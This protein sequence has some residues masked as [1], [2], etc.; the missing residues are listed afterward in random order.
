MTDIEICLAAE[1]R[2]WSALLENDNGTPDFFDD[3]VRRTAPTVPGS[4]HFWP[5]W[6]A[7]SA[8]TPSSWI[9]LEHNYFGLPPELLEEWRTYRKRW[10]DL[11]ELNPRM[12]IAEMLSDISEGHDSSSFPHGWE[13]HVQDWVRSGCRSEPSFFLDLQTRG[14]GFQDR[15][16]AAAK[17]AGKG[18]IYYVSGD[19]P[20][21]EWRW[22]DDGIA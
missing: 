10:H 12:W 4:R 7:N 11:L 22:D 9:G 20:R 5:R 15:F 17:A 14:L 18:W 6:D 8:F 3:L 19:D 16:M 1:R 13:H 2:L 21:Y